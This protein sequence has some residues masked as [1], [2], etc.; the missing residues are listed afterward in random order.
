MVPR[1]NSDPSCMI[2][3]ELEGGTSVYGEGARDC[4]RSWHPGADHTPHPRLL[5]VAQPFTMEGCAAPA[6]LFIVW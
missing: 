5:L 1:E 3:I 4:C 2:D 6:L